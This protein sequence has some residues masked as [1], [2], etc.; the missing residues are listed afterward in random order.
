M[1]SGSG[2]GAMSIDGKELVFKTVE[3]P[4]AD[5]YGQSTQRVCYTAH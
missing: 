3:S 2:W 4:F 5:V 1:L